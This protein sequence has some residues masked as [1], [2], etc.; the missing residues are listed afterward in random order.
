[1]TALTREEKNI[2]CGGLVEMCRH[3]ML[4]SKTESLNTVQII[5][6]EDDQANQNLFKDK[7]PSNG[8]I[9]S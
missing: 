7:Q 8:K 6:N 5:L 9:N 1:M 4:L 3:D 2:L